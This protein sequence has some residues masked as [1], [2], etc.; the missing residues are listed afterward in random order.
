[1]IFLYLNKMKLR[2]G[3]VSNN[4]S[5]SYMFICGNDFDP[6]CLDVCIKAA[7]NKDLYI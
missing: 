6:K 1:M 5:S 4:S 3:F 2:I 7:K